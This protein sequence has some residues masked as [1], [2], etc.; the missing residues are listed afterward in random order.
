[1]VGYALVYGGRPP[2]LRLGF[3]FGL[4]GIGALI[5]AAQFRF[6][7]SAWLRMVVIMTA[8]SL[9]PNLSS[10]FG[11][12]TEVAIFIVGSFALLA[13]AAINQDTLLHSTS[14]SQPYQRP[15]VPFG[16]EGA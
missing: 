3:V 15:R 13:G 8:V 9:T 11:D 6:Q 14:S 4:A 10:N 7:G 12:G 16:S 2:N 5:Q 1:M